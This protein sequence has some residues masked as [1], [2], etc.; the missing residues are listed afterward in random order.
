MSVNIIDI[1]YRKYGQAR[2][3]LYQHTINFTNALGSGNKT[4]SKIDKF[5]LMSVLLSYVE[6]KVSP[7]TKV[8]GR[9]TTHISLTDLNIEAYVGPTPGTEGG[10]GI[11]DGVFTF[12]KIPLH[13]YTNDVYGNTTT[14]AYLQPNWGLSNNTNGLAEI[15]TGVIVG[16]VIDPFDFLGTTLPYTNNVETASQLLTATNRLKGNIVNSINSRNSVFTA[17]L[18]NGSIKIKASQTSLYNGSE[19]KASVGAVS[20]TS[21]PPVFLKGITA[22]PETNN[23][24]AKDQKNILNTLDILAAELEII[25][26]ESEDINYIIDS[27]GSSILEGEETSNMLATDL[28]N[29]V[30]E[31]GESIDGE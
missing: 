3:A 28:G 1:I 26:T 15:F 6:N 10:T 31:S 14:I 18:S 20:F 23:I 21:S 30:T 12:T 7:S 24:S 2:K 16:E 22:V 19:I 8:E 5:N 13:I 25:Y 17:S 29:L 11:N 9:D 27:E 4:R